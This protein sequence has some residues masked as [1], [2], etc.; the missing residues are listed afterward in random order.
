MGTRFRA[1]ACPVDASTGDKRRFADDSL[2]TQ[3]LPMPGRWV[4][5]DV[6]AHDNAVTVASLDKVEMDGAE[7]WVEGEWLDDADPALMPRLAED[8]TEA[9][10]LARKGVLGFS[11]D[12]DDFEVAPVTTGSNDLA[13]AEM[14][15]DPEADIELLI[16]KGRIRSATLVAIP[17]YVET[18]HTI[19]FL[20]EDD[21]AVSEPDTEPVDEDEM[22]AVTAAVTGET[23]M[24]VAEREHEW[25]GGAARRRVL[26]HFTDADGNLDIDA[27]AKAFLWVDRDGANASD[28]D[29]V[30][31]S[32]WT[33]AFANV[34]EMS[35]R[36]SADSARETATSLTPATNGYSK[37][38]AEEVARLTEELEAAK[39]AASIPP[40]P[41]TPHGVTRAANSSSHAAVSTAKLIQATGPVPTGARTAPGNANS[42]PPVN[43]AAL[44]TQTQTSTGIRSASATANTASPSTTF[45]NS[46][47]SK[48]GSALS[49]QPPSKSK[50]SATGEAT[51][52]KLASTTTTRPGESGDSSATLVTRGSGTLATTP[53]DSNEQQR[54]FATLPQSAFKLGFADIL[55]GEL[56]IIPRG[57]AATAGGRGV[58]AADIP[59]ADKDAIKSRICS[60][61]EQ[62]RKEFS[63]WPECPFTR[64]D[65]E[66]EDAE[67]AV[68]ASVGAVYPVEAFRA[69]VA[70]DGP[71]PITYDLDAGVVYG[72]VA[73]WGVCHVGIPRTCV[74]AP[75]DPSGE[76]RE[77]HSHRVATTDGVIYAGRITAGGGHPSS[78]DDTITAHAVRKA[79]DEK[80]T[81]AYVI[82]TEDD[83]GIF[84]CGPLVR[85]NLDA[86][87]LA[88]LS[89]RK[90]SADWRE[91]VDGMSMVEVL[92]LGPGSP[93][94]SEPGFPVLAAFAGGRQIALTASLSPEVPRTGMLISERIL[95]ISERTEYL[96]AAFREAYRVIKTEEAAERAR[97]FAAANLASELMEH[98]T[99]DL[100]KN[101]AR[102]MGDG[103]GL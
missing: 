8:V 97:M 69:P 16:T 71:T 96:S 84:V 70:V 92:A 25:D 20:G 58:D 98:M 53:T 18:N 89:R 103:R 23:D 38:G 19:T 45:K 34:V 62:V 86:D 22:F 80:T 46:T 33:H 83:H 44:T 81:V 78:L 74:T 36:Q 27:A 55:D 91:T 88:V 30:M 11:V 15:E 51:P 49:A 93:E 28:S 77:F 94:V 65:A 67:M 57:V 48:T 21:E 41:A 42:I 85:E 17:A 40:E 100:R 9:K 24:P 68:T 1:L 82:A 56:T 13:S 31:L 47:E 14:L 35:P 87:T 7:V 66:P 3:P 29:D 59:D 95:E 2:T 61:Y 52:A 26:D 76:Y 37:T 99:A 12:L 90:V 60:L 43:A 39:R 102:A 73:P 32:G 79:H 50:Y 75:H 64:D 63:D 101:L 4:R 6:G 54:T 10:Y 72:H 5:E